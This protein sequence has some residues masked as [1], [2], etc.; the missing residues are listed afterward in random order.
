MVLFCIA[1][2]LTKQVRVY[3]SM[4]LRIDC[5]EFVAV[6]KYPNEIHHHTV[7]SNCFDCVD[8]GASILPFII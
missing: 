3:L 7:Y 4:G 6:E 2:K 8:I 5:S 1:T